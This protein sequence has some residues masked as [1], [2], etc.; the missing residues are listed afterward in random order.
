[1]CPVRLYNKHLNLKIMKKSIFLPL[2][3][4]STMMAFTSCNQVEEKGQ[5]TLGLDM[6]EEGM[7]KAASDNSHVTTALITIMREDGSMMYDKEPIELIR[8]GDALVTRALK[9]PVGG[10]M[11]TEFMLTDSSGVVL[12]ATPK[13]GSPLAGL[14]NQPLPQY[15]K[16]HPDEST[17]V[18]IQVIRVGNHPPEDFGYARFNIDFV[19]RFCLKVHY[20]QRC[21]DY[22]SILGPDGAVMPFYQG[23]LRVFIYDR[24]VLDEPMN[25]GENN[26]ALPSG[27]RHYLL[28]ATG[29]KGQ[30]IFKQDFGMEELGR[31]RCDPDFP[32]LIIPGKDDPDI[33]ITPEGLYEPSIKQGL[34]GQ[35][36]PP[37]DMYMDSTLVA[38]EFLVKEIHIFPFSVLDSI[39]TFAPIGCHISP[40]MLPEKPLA[41]VISNSE[42]YFQAALR[43]G[44]YLFLVRTEE[45]YYI[46]AFISS[47]RPGYALVKTGEVSYVLV[48]LMDCSM[49]M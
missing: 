10:F 20:A 6:V 49:W 38:A 8:F 4:L 32:A 16:I 12:W 37:L 34:F 46:D 15:F 11:L 5:L 21:P 7:Q 39:Y 40:D 1:M 14:V 18:N 30:T 42:G 29:C 26:F 27:S 19:E 23:R 2:A 47:H 44:E 9:L 43:A 17:R 25:P 33:I 24:L 31:F 45:G 13:E 3:L 48:N 35:I 41:R 36:M 28:V 22:D